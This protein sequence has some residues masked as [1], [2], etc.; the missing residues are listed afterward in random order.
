[1]KGSTKVRLGLA[2]VGV[3]AVALAAMPANAST[4]YAVINGNGSLSTALTPTGPN[5]LTFTFGGSGVAVTT[6]YQGTFSCAVHGDDS[7]GTIT[8]GTGSFS[9]SCTAGTS[10]PVS[11]TYTRVGSVVTLSGNIGPGP[12][13]GS[14]TGGCTFEVTDTTADTFGVQCHVAVN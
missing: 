5:P 11:G 3:A 2:S 9:G 8:Q 10:E 1:M 7:V 14:F 6:T 12:V 13:T 4:G